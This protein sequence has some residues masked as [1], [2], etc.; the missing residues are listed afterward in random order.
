MAGSSTDASDQSPVSTGIVCLA[1]ASGRDVTTREVSKGVDTSV[2]NERLRHTT[3]EARRIL[4]AELR[5]TM[6]DMMRVRA[7]VYSLLF[8]APVVSAC[9]TSGFECGTPLESDPDQ[10]YTCGRPEEVC[11]CSTRSC[12][13][14]E[15][16]ASDA[17][18]PCAS[19]LRYVS[20]ADFVTLPARPGECVD[21]AHA[22]GTVLAQE[23]QS[24]CPGSP[25]LPAS[26][27]S[28]SSSGTTVAEPTS[29]T[30]TSTA[31]GSGTDPATT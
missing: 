28:E 18:K 26:T 24:R 20:E 22:D 15:H 14:P 1:G 10:T 6:R 21:E 12:A 9:S 4:A 19:K 11:I 13:R 29:S 17:K 8:A 27:G 3:R 23:G 2:E 31:T 7:V 25:A 16:A 5:S 30:T